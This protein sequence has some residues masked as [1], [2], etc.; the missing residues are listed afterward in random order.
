MGWDTLQNFCISRRMG[1]SSKISVPWDGVIHTTFPFHPTR[2]PVVHVTSVKH[3]RIK[4]DQNAVINTCL[5][6]QLHY[7][8]ENQTKLMIVLLG[9]IAS[10]SY[11]SGDTCYCRCCAGHSFTPP[12]LGTIALSS[13]TSTTCELSCQNEYPTQC[14]NGTGS[15][16]Y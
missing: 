13:C 11:C 5:A 9:V 6:Y 10:I 14:T 3:L 12:L 16:S 1:Q 2:S 7:T 4:S 8:M 15:S